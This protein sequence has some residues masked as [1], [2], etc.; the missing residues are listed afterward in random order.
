[1]LIQK[2]Y[3]LVK[4]IGDVGNYQTFLAVDK[5]RFPSV[6]CIVHKLP[7]N[8]QITTVFINKVEK[9]KILNHNPQITKLVYFHTE[10]EDDY[11]EDDYLVYEFI[12]GDNLKA[13]SAKESIFQEMPI[14]QKY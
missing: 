1:M 14:W 5:G 6:S 8:Q 3:R 2:R 7:Q 9:L 10:Y 11:H 4:L 13:I 12:A